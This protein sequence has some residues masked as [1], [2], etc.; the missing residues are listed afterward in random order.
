MDKVKNI[1]DNLEKYIIYVLFTILIVLM[2]T[3]VV[4][5]YLFATAWGWMET[6]TRLLFVYITF[7]GMSWA[8]KG[9][10]HLRVSFVAEFAPG[11]KTKTILF[12]IGDIL[13]VLVC[14]YMGSLI[15]AMTWTVYTSKQVYTSAAWLPKW[16]LYFP[17]FIGL[18]GMAIRT[19]QYGVIP[20]LKALKKYDQEGGNQ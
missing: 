8:C 9:S 6:I 19:I 11:K 13:L 14:A 10:E 2:F 7:A 15:A 12:L 16:L 3:Q 1:L 17:G 5:R 4:A 18:W 20:G